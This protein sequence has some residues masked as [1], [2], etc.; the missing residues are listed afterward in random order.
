MRQLSFLGFQIGIAGMAAS[1]S[2]ALFTALA[3]LSAF[4]PSPL[5][6]PLRRTAGWSGA[7]IPLLFVVAGWE[8]AGRHE[9]AEGPAWRA[10]MI[11]LYPCYLGLVLI[12]LIVSESL[13]VA[14]AAQLRPSCALPGEYIMVMPFPFSTWVD[15]L[16]QMSSAA[17][18]HGWVFGSLVFNEALGSPTAAVLRTAA[19][20][21][22]MLVAVGAYAG[23]IWAAAA[24]LSPASSS[25][26]VGFGVLRPLTPCYMAGLALGCLV[27]VTPHR[28]LSTPC[29]PSAHFLL[30][31][32]RHCDAHPPTLLVRAAR[33]DSLA[34]SGSPPSRELRSRTDSGKQSSRLRLRPLV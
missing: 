16:R 14:G 23:T 21:C 10:M 34:L 24:E 1:V 13:C 31:S 25:L 33:S 11:E 18:P 26:Q 22:S 15:D 5:P 2:A 17:A 32:T 9:R 7:L 20:W 28:H 8:A 27:Q 6:Q 19:P 12:A 3:D 30:D 4:A 29:Q